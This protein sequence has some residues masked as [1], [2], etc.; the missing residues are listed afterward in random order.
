MENIDEIK[1]KYSDSVI[2]NL[3]EENFYKIIGFLEKEKCNFI[4]DIVSDYLDILTFDYNEFLDKYNKLNKKYNYE[5]LE[6][7]SEDM[8]LLEELYTVE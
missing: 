4:D 6:K 7:V 5:Y 3:D 2:K 8:N 1:A